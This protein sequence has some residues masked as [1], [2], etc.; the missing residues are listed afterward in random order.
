M[1]LGRSFR[2]LW[3]G[4]ASA[5]LADGI[6]F[7]SIPLI[8]TSV[9]SDAVLIAGL[10]AVYSAVRLFVVLPVGVYVDRIE[11]RTV[12]WVANLV[13]A[14]LLVGVGALF[15]TGAESIAVLYVLYAV[16]GTFETAADNA[17]VSL[18]PSLV[19][20]TQLD[21]GNGRLS[22][23]QLVVDEFVGPP[24][25]GF[26]FAA[27]VALPLYVMGG[28][29]AIAA[30]F[31]LALPLT[32]RLAPADKSPKER[33][34]VF[35]EAAQGANWLRR[36]QLL[37]GLAI[38]GGLASVAYMMPFSILVLYAEQTLDLSAAGYGVILSISAVGGLVGSFITA[39]LRS[40]IGYSRT[41]AGS[42]A[43]MRNPRRAG[44][45]QHCLGGS[46]TA[47]RLYTARRRLGHLRH[48]HSATTCA[49]KPE[50]KSECGF[51]SLRPSRSHS[52][53]PDG[54][55]AGRIAHPG[56]SVPRRRN[57]FR[58]L[59]SGCTASFPTVPS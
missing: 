35:R 49:R 43:W 29:Y 55:S 13:R 34:S 15:S 39:P 9:T 53:R 33:G 6:A 57:H 38:I 23:A 4:S 44:I 18:V 52:W 47:G 11:R 20:V 21:R 14:A 36:H 22:A 40:R 10:A 19:P 5:N 3:S 54:R 59:R 45:H 42:L 48:L 8:A 24:L 17:S 50:G 37:R 25:G 46:G 26:L 7:I 1:G 28:M 27:T 41:V 30:A 31:F 12:L 2:K 58:L 16:L 56:G 51:Q 32:P